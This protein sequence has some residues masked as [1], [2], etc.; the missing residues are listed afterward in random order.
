MPI[1]PYEILGVRSNAPLKEIKSAYRELVK[2]HHPDTGGDEEMILSLNAAW[3]IL[4]DSESREAFDLE[5]RINNSFIKKTKSRNFRNVQ[6]NNLANSVKTKVAEEEDELS[7]WLKDIYGPINKLIGQV[8]N[9]FQK[10][11]RELSGDPYDDH[12]ME[13]FCSYI[14]DSQ[15]KLKKVE[16]LYRSKIAPNSAEGLAINLY[17]CFSQLQDAL[18]EIDKYTM[19]YVDNY[20]HDGQE[21]IREAKKIRSLLQEERGNLPRF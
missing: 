14:Q 4:R 21:M 1:N 9:P 3:E 7:L 11:I 2:R 17:R 12:L 13:S 19:G 6:A 18:N 10:K 15:V 8:I 16:Y 5:A 20:L